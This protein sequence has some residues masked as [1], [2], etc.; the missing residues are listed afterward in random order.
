MNLIHVSHNKLCENIHIIANKQQL[1]LYFILTINW[2][3]VSLKLEHLTMFVRL[4]VKRVTS[5]S[6]ITF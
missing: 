2:S 5:M 1:I 4:N 6:I 3:I